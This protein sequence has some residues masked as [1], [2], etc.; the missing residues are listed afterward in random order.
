MRRARPKGDSRADARSG[1]RPSTALAAVFVAL[2]VPASADDTFV[3]DSTADQVDVDLVNVSCQTAAGTCTLRAAVM[4]AN[5]NS[6]D[7]TIFLPPGLFAVTRSP[8]GAN[9]ADSGDLNLAKPATEGSITIRGAGAAATIVDGG[10]LDRIFR[11]EPGVVA[12]IEELTVRNGTAENGGGILAHGQLGLTAVRI[13]GNT[14]NLRGG[15]LYIDTTLSVFVEYSDVVANQSAL[16]GG[17][18]HLSANADGLVFLRNS[19][20]QQNSARYG[21]AIFHSGSGRLELQRVSVSGNQA[22]GGGGLAIHEPTSDNF[23]HE[24]TFDDNHATHELFGNGGAIFTLATL[25]VHNS[26]ISGNTATRN[27]GAVH[28][29]GSANLYNSTVVFNQADIDADPNGG[30]GGGLY[31]ES[32]GTLA[33][34]NSVLAGNYRSGAP[35]A[36]DC[37]GTLAS[38]GHNRFGSFDG[39][40]ISHGGNCGGQDLLLAS[41]TELGPLRFNGGATRTHAIQA[42]SSLI[43]DVDPN[44]ICQ[45]WMGN[46]LASDQRGGPRVAG[47]RCDVG[48]FEYGALPPGSLFADDFELGH[49][50]LWR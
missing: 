8:S 5:V 29:E 18:L 43:D 22:A 19:S 1:P 20:L 39:C 49:S 9:T 15:G 30:R 25:Y 44:C 17:G 21:G 37:F 42:G 26:T 31:N 24:S 11:I 6:G 3:V 32:S 45:N 23:I 40:A 48:A 35:V 38:Y 50:L 2:A 14:A 36:D 46:A 16:D 34:R 28:N 47:A 7:A 12:W 13:A 33:I 4:Q 27:G 10:D 41:T